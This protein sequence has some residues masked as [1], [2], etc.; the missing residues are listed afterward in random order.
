ME[1]RPSTAARPV[2][3]ERR[4]RLPR[5]IAPLL[6]VLVGV[7]LMAAA[8]VGMLGVKIRRPYLIVGWAVVIAMG[9]T[10]VMALYNPFDGS[11]AV[12]FDPLTDAAARV[13]AR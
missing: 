4:L 13:A 11:V 1:S 6:V 10:V 5:L 9:L 8:T 12:T 3:P 2:D 7:G